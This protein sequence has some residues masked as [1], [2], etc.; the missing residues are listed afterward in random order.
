MPVTRHPLSAL[1]DP[2]LRS[3]PVDDATI[4]R[5][6]ASLRQMATAPAAPGTDLASSFYDIL[7]TGHP[8]LRRMFPADMTAQKKKLLDQLVMVVEHLR[9]P[10]VVRAR[11]LQLGANHKGYGAKTEHYPVVVSAIVAAMCHV[12]G[13]A[14]S[15]ELAHEWL[16]A[17]DLV[18]DIMLEGARNVKPA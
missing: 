3:V 1:T 4:A 8:Q 18:S 15:D 12:S 13:P 16:T 10:E 6:E 17:L 14:W 5:L 2:R 7:F 11:L 9:S